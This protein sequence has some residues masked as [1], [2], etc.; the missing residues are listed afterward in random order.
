MEADIIPPQSDNSSTESI[1]ALK[2]KLLSKKQEL[3]KQK[4]EYSEAITKF[5]GDSVAIWD[6]IEEIKTNAKKHSLED[7]QDEVEKHLN[8]KFQS[9]QPSL[10]RREVFQD[11]HIFDNDLKEEAQ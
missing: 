9:I 8:I 3:E 7:I 10:R 2:A 1:E 6:G 5:Q 4:A 11:L